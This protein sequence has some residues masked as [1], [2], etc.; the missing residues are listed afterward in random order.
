MFRCKQD[1]E[2]QQQNFK[3]YLRPYFCQCLYYRPTDLSL[4]KVLNFKHDFN[5]PL[6]IPSRV[7]LVVL[8]LGYNFCKMPSSENMSRHLI[9]SKIVMMHKTKYLWTNQ[10]PQIHTHM[11]SLVT[12]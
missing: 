7:I 10:K 2:P 9:G 6:S 12:I 1:K 4:S 8:N 11:T 3:F 5:L